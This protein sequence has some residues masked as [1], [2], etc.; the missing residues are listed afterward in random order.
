MSD[1]EKLIE[2]LNEGVMFYYKTPFI[3]F[4]G[5]K[6]LMKEAAEKIESLN[7][8]IN[9]LKKKRNPLSDAEIENEHYKFKM[10]FAWD[11]GFEVGVKF[12]EKMHKIGVSDDYDGNAST[13]V[14]TAKASY[15][16]EKAMLYE[17]KRFQELSNENQ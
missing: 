5:T 2:K 9:E 3:N 7:T 11:R 17:K 8:K 1:I 16:Q 6:K 4:V 14:M 12:A 10:P 13:I 15:N